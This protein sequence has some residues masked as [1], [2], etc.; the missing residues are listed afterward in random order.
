MPPDENESAPLPAGILVSSPWAVRT[1]TTEPGGAPL[2]RTMG[3]LPLSIRQWLSADAGAGACWAAVPSGSAMLP[4][5]AIGVKAAGGRAGGAGHHHPSAASAA[6]PAP[7][8][9]ATRR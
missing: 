9:A 5:V 2:Q 4:T 1:W 6:A 7:A 8:P 3:R